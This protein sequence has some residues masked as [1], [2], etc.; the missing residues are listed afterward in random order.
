M[1]GAMA[2]ASYHTVPQHEPRVLVGPRPG[3]KQHASRGRLRAH[4]GHEVL[5]LADKPPA[6]DVVIERLVDIS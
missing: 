1:Y 4:C 5:V 3:V 6:L 2:F